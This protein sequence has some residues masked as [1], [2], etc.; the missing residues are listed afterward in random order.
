VQHADRHRRLQAHVQVAGSVCGHGAGVQ[1]HE[2]VHLTLQLSH[3]LPQLPVHSGQ[4]A[5]RVLRLRS[6]GGKP[7]PQVDA[8]LRQRLDARRRLR[9]RPLLRNRER[10]GVRESSVSLSTVSRQLAGLPLHSLPR[11][12]QL[13]VHRLILLDLGVEL[14]RQRV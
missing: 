10:V 13:D 4:L 11:L 3:A 1:R 6:D 8:A 5:L 14:A 7:L 9:V 12:E 2:S